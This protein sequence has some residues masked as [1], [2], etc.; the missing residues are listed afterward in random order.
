MGKRTRGGQCFGCEMS[1][2]VDVV[3]VAVSGLTVFSAEWK[4]VMTKRPGLR[5]E[6]GS[7]TQRRGLR[8]Q[9]RRDGQP[10]PDKARKRGKEQQEQCFCVL[11]GC[12][13][14]AVV[15]AA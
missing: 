5:L 13:V 12:V 4:R 6:V 1:N 3:A 11:P 2:R 9:Q 7:R 10:F 14:A 15:V 8:L